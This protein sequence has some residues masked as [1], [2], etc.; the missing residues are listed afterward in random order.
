MIS[1]KGNLKPQGMKFALDNGAWWCYQH[2]KPFDADAFMRALDQFWFDADFIVLPDIV[3]GGRRSLDFSLEWHHRLKMDGLLLLPVQDGMLPVHVEPYLSDVGL[4][5]G[6]TTAFKESTA[7]EWASLA[8]S[9]DAYIHCGRV[10]SQRRLNLCKQAGIDSFD[11]SGPAKFQL[12]AEVMNR[13]LN[14]GSLRF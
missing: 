13:E 5:I 7:F 6:G 12:H 2:G 1:A 3:A 4:F 8:R 11:G 9:H 10:N 14:Q